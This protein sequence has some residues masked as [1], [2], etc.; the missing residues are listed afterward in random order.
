MFQKVKKK[1]F[2]PHQAKNFLIKPSLK[3]EH[4]KK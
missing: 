4:I 2:K 3:Y 1:N